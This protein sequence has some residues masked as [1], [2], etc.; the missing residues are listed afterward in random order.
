MTRDRDAAR[1]DAARSALTL[2]A[3]E[4]APPVARNGNHATPA[5]AGTMHIVA[6]KDVALRSVR[7]LW[8]HYLPLG[9]LVVIDGYPG[10]GKSTFVLDVA[11]RLSR[12]APMPDGSAGAPASDTIILTYEDDA[13]DT[14]RPRLE[15]AGGD[16]ARVHHVAG[17]SYNGDDLL[18]PPSLPKDLALLELALS[19]RPAVRFVVV[20]PLMAALGADVD[21]H[22]DQD[23][24]RV[25][26]RLARLAEQAGVCIAIIR[27]VRK[28]H[29][30]N[31]ITAG[32]GSIGI[33]GQARVGLLVDR[34]PEDPDAA[35]LAVVKSNI[36]P[37]APSLTF[38]KVSAEIPGKNGEPIS[39]SRLEW[40]G[41]ANL[42]ADELLS[43][44]DDGEAGE[45]HDVD[46]WLA[47]L[48]SAGRID[49]KT[50]I[51][52][53]RDNGF[54]ER[55]VGRA[56]KRLGVV[57]ERLGFGPACHSEWYIPTPGEPCTPAIP[58]TPATPAARA[59][60]AGVGESGRSEATASD[61]AGYVV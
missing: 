49:R 46:E 18:L 54:P 41:A 39:T 14:L 4:D 53:G 48:L 28:S 8:R 36:G 37:L 19:E 24:R 30:G 9:K 29:G 20:D 16:A 27:H 26:A 12:G 40:T 57:K 44:H 43:A 15:A 11:A 52:S 33:I 21:S 10:Q 17:V 7:W 47:G 42:T 38:R 25:L 5:T 50:V 35:V 58:A 6:L 55:T 56:A 59:G 3:P 2:L 45:A 32:G 51:A 61:L 1:F 22:R 34:H 60:L 31:A 23:V 13:A